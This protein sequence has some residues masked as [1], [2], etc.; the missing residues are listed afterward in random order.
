MATLSIRNIPDDVRDRLRIR[1]AKAGRSL[2]AELRLIVTEAARE[3]ASASDGLLALRE[4][5]RQWR[6]AN[7]DAPGVVDELIAERRE[8]A[9]REFE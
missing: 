1:A 3:E 7:P 6:A 2:E 4:H 9:R 5:M 8:E